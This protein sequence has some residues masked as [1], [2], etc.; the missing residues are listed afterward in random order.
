M[1]VY[2]GVY[3]FMRCYN[4]FGYGLTIL[5]SCALNTVSNG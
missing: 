3:I 1:S 5:V 4:L 2:K